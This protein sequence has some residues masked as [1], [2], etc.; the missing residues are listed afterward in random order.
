MLL[1]SN[2]Y[3]YL[4]RLPPGTLSIAFT[5]AHP[6]CLSD[7][8]GGVYC[9]HQ[10]RRCSGYE[11]TGAQFEDDSI[12]LAVSILEN[13]GCSHYGSDIRNLK[14]TITF[15]TDAQLHIKIADADH[16]RYEIPKLFL[17]TG[18]EWQ[19][20]DGISNAKLKFNY[21]SRPF[22]FAVQRKDTNETIFD[23][24]VAG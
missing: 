18:D 4:S 8:E 23:T 12:H 22:A 6:D 19:T 16:D 9:F 7:V 1:V 5:P 13:S 15:E 2:R 3:I 21:R 20:A 14:V 11:V 24:D 17:P 10:R